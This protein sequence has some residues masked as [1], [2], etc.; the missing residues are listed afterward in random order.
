MFVLLTLHA[1][2]ALKKIL[3]HLF[4]ILTQPFHG[5]PQKFFQGGNV[6]SL[7]VIFKL[8]M[9]VHKTLYPCYTATN[10][11]CFGSIHKNCASLAVTTRQ[12]F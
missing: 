12:G 9:D 10:V 1:D 5:R 3:F 11:P 8:Q 4:S 7:L 6:G 2:L